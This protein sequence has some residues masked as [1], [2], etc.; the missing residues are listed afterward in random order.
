LCVDD[1]L[2]VLA[3]LSDTLKPEG[4]DVETAID[5]THALE[6]IATSEPP[7][8]LIILDGRMPNVDGR[9]FLMWARSGGYQGKVIVFSAWLDDDERQRYRQLNVDA[10]IEKPPKPGELI[11][12]VRQMAK[13]PS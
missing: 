13:R 10:L 6:K 7:Y 3:L 5:G 11:A 4:Y 8:D 12:A 1:D 9:R 2:R